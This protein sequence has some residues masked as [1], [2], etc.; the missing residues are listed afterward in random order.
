MW[1]GGNVVSLCVTVHQI[2]DLALLIISYIMSS[3]PFLKLELGRQNQ[4]IFVKASLFIP[5]FCIWRYIQAIN[6]IKYKDDHCEA[7]CSNCVFCWK[8][9]DSGR[10]RFASPECILCSNSA[11]FLTMLATKSN[12]IFSRM[13]LVYL[14]FSP[15]FYHLV[16][17]QL[18]FDF[19]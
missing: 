5:A 9:T 2:Q 12:W 4:S 8:S 15:S 16:F 10:P 13:K 7:G 19:D 3:N 18:Q 17:Y 6:T 1:A 11:I 14:P